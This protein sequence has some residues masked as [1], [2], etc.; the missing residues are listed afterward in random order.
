MAMYGTGKNSKALTEERVPESQ[1]AGTGPFPPAAED[2]FDPNIVLD[3]ETSQV[4]YKTQTQKQATKLQ[5]IGPSSDHMLR[6]H[7]DG[8][9]LRNG[10]EGAF[11]GVGVYFGP[12]DNRYAGG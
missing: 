1:G 9:S 4:V 10:Q 3:P 6:I 7:T 11:A 5:A 2:G 8:S 12:S